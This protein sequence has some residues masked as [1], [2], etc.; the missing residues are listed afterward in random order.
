MTMNTSV[1]LRNTC[2]EN[3]FFRFLVLPI[4]PTHTARLIALPFYHND[5]FDRLFVAQ[6]LTERIPIVIADVQLDAYGVT[7]I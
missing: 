5:P 4:L 3:P 6:A 1:T 2:R 7:R